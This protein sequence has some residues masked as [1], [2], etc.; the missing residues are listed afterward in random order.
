VYVSR[1]ATGPS[2]IG[3]SERYFKAG[4]SAVISDIGGN[5]IRF[6]GGGSPGGDVE[7]V[8][9]WRGGTR[10]VAG[11]VL[12]CRGSICESAIFTRVFGFS[13]VIVTEVHRFPSL[14]LQLV[15]ARRV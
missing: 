7:A 15:A 13:M 12:P 2:A 8:T 14:S 1:E 6:E 4:I 11:A 3:G 5:S 9:R 10:G